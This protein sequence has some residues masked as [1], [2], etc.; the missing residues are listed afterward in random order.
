MAGVVDPFEDSETISPEDHQW[1]MFAPDPSASYSW[2]TV[3]ATRTDG[4]EVD[5]LRGTRLTADPPADAAATFPNF[6][7]RQYALSIPGSGPRVQ[8]MVDA[9]CDSR[10]VRRASPNHPYSPTHQPHTGAAG[11]ADD[12]G[13]PVVLK[14][15]NGIRS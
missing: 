9:V 10:A 13:K 3:A 5:V 11:R 7:W 4:T 14:A 15:V 2:L 8:T 12:A 6:R 1:E